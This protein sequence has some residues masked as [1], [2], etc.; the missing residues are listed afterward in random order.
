MMALCVCGWEIL[1]K[2]SLNDSM[3]CSSIA[4]TVRLF[5]Q[6]KVGNVIIV[7]NYLARVKVLLLNVTAATLNAIKKVSTR[8]LFYNE[9]RVF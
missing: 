1:M 2:T 6:L 9:H 3:E 7:L 5:T 4:L 8:S